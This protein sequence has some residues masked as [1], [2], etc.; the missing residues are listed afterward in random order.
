[1]NLKFKLINNLILIPVEL[2]QKK[3]TFILDTGVSKSLLFNV[4]STDSL[5]LKNLK[6]VR[7]RGLGELEYFNA[8]KSRRNFCRIDKLISLDFEIYLIQDKQFDF[9][10]RLGENVH[11]LIGYDLLKNFIVEINYQKRIITFNKKEKYKY[12]KRKKYV[13]FPIIFQKN[14]PYIDA[15]IL[16]NE[17]NKIPVRLLI[18]SGSGDALWLFENDKIKVPNK[19]FEDY[20]GSGL[21]GEI[22]G[23]KSLQNQFKLQN[24]VM[25]DVLVSF[26][27]SE[28][29]KASNTNIQRNGII[30]S[31]ILRRFHIILDYSN[32][33]ISLRKNKN[34]KEP[35]YYNR[36]G[37]DIIYNG[38]ILIKSANNTFYGNL[39]SN[40]NEYNNSSAI[41]I[42][43]VYN[44]EFKN[45]YIINSIKEN[46]EA[47]KIGLKVG[48]IVLS[49]NHKP[50][51][52]YDL[53]GI[54]QELSNKKRKNINLKI[55]RNGF[56]HTFTFDLVDLL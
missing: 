55:I 17:S 43:Y 23:K 27:N 9:S 42:S 40:S 34:F 3:F 12:K 51:Y 52:F 2:N 49:I 33:Q 32:K 46:S 18:D 35:F 5:K 48:D 22:H 36:S 45:S 19:F 11:G 37:L 47:D 54:I 56:E 44:Y 16:N 38:K 1:M 39:K 8:I 28:Y 30:G 14:K 7:V 6:T 21:S 24:F 29:V 10:A 25:K 15:Y 13:Y 41:S 50:T 53:K 26:P 31:E 20:L 4:K